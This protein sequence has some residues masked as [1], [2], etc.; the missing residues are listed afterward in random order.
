MK[1]SRCGAN[2]MGVSI[3]LSES[4]C[5]SRHGD[6]QASAESW[7]A[8]VRRSMVG[9]RIGT[10]N[11]KHQPYTDSAWVCHGVS[12]LLTATHGKCDGARDF[13]KSTQGFQIVGMKRHADRPTLHCT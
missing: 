13:G 11:S 7:G 4:S 9:E 6:A 8:W 12:R 1:R 2:G 3:P 5:Y 10:G